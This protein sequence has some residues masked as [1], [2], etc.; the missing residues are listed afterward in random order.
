[1]AEPSL[2]ELAWTAACARLIFGPVTQIQVPPNL[3]P[4]PDDAADGGGAVGDREGWRGCSRRRQRWGGSPGVTPDHVSPEAPWPHLSELARVTGRRATRSSRG[5]RRRRGTSSGNDPSSRPL[6]TRR[7]GDEDEPAKPGAARFL[8]RHRREGPRDG[9]SERWIDARSRRTSGCWPTRRVSRGHPDGVRV[10]TSLQRRTT[11]G[12][13]EPPSKPWLSRVPRPADVVGV[14][15]AVFGGRVRVTRVGPDH[16]AA[17]RVRAAIE[18][19]QRRGA[20]LALDCSRLCEVDG[21]AKSDSDSH[22]RTRWTSTRPR[23]RRC[24]ARGGRFRRRVRR[25][26]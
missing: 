3:T 22:S 19:L 6:H 8:L 26:G 4:E 7:E 5:S 2:D 9:G 1:M 15:G 10:A 13:D 11:T 24:C 16:P 23:W 18:R 20:S 17:P 25:R 21:G 14:D 12:E